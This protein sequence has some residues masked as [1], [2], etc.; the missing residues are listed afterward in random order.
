MLTKLLPDQISAFWDVIKYAIEE[1]LPPTV[2]EN[3]DKMNRILMSLLS[4]KAQ[5]WVS[6]TINKEQRKLEGIIITRVSYDDV[7]D[8]KNLLIY[9]L[10]GYGNVGRANILSGF[11]TLVKYASSRDCCRIVGYTDL[12]YVVELA[13]RFGGDTGYTFVSIPLYKN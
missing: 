1:S 8:T 3:P 7:S 11:K 10:Y 2:S 5:C 13:K 6:Y 9:C 4:D 12:P